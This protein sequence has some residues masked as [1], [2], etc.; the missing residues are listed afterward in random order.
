MTRIQH[1]RKPL[2]PKGG[3]QF[4]KSR[5]IREVFT[6]CGAPVTD[7][8]GG[9]ASKIKSFTWEDGTQI[10]ACPH[11]ISLRDAAKAAKKAAS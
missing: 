3:N 9:P 6:F 10:E 5:A 1:L 8:D 7:I 11:C 2:P 4:Y